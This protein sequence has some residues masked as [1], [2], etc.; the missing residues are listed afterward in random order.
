V[1]K[2][3]VCVGKR[4]EVEPEGRSGERSRVVRV[5]RSPSV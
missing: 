3:V 2:V 4:I 5:V 1:C